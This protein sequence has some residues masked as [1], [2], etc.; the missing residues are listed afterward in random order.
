MRPPAFESENHTH[1]AKKN[2]AES[3]LRLFQQNRSRADE[4]APICDAVLPRDLLDGAL[5]GGGQPECI[6]AACSHFYILLRISLG[7]R[8]SMANVSATPPKS[9]ALNVAI[10]SAC[11]FTAASSTM[12]SSA[13][14]SATDRDPRSASNTPKHEAH[15]WAAAVLVDEF[16][17]AGAL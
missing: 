8:S 16:D 4:T 17:A 2:W 9:R 15:P 10:A 14:Q 12:S 13:C 1:G 11:P 3:T 6:V 7:V 5:E